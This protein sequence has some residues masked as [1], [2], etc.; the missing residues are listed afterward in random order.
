LKLFFVIL[1]GLFATIPA[2]ILIDKNL[3]VPSSAILPGDDV[4]ILN[5]FTKGG[6]YTDPG[7]NEFDYGITR[8]TLINVSGKSLQLKINFPAD[9]FA[10]PAGAWYV[11][12]LVLPDT[13]SFND[14]PFDK[15][16]LYVSDGF[17]TF[18]DV[19][20][21]SSTTFQDTIS[22]G[23]DRILYI[24]AVYHK[25]KGIP[26]A[27]LVL[28]DNDLFFRPGLFDSLIPCGKITFK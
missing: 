22:P 16:S 1:T 2:Y 26:R 28:K 5:S 4:I 11:K 8:T 18:L 14:M 19:G 20:L 10:F 6:E 12:L 21:K 25:T 17:K 15:S 7:G 27:E 23:K 13:I 3:S 9:S 24:A